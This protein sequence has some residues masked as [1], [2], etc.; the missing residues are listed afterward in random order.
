MPEAVTILKEQ[1]MRLEKPEKRQ[2]RG[3]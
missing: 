1:N 3:L 2:W